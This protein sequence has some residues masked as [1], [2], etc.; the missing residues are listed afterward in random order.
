M[1]NDRRRHRINLWNDNER[2]YRYIHYNNNNAITYPKII[3]E[4]LCNKLG[5]TTERASIAMYDSHTAKQ[6]NVGRRAKE[7]NYV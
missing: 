3:L 6:I 1:S 4:L 2:L 7:I 5:T